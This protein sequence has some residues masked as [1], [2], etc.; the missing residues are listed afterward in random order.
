[1]NT[2][3]EV[4]AYDNQRIAQEWALPRELNTVRPPHQSNITAGLAKTS[5]P[6]ALP[7]GF[8]SPRTRLP[9]IPQNSSLP[10]QQLV[11][12]P[13]S[14]EMRPPA[15]PSPLPRDRDFS[16]RPS[17]GSHKRARGNSFDSNITSSTS[18]YIGRSSFTNLSGPQLQRL[19]MQLR[20]SGFFSSSSTSDTTSLLSRMSR[21]SIEVKPCIMAHTL[22][23]PHNPCPVCRY[24]EPQPKPR[25]YVAPEY[26]APQRAEVI[27]SDEMDNGILTGNA[28][29]RT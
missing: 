28:N 2:A 16:V 26:A 17:L 27:D 23:N 8:S 10:S 11:V 24:P 18:R 13:S 9:T 14:I 19:E 22:V 6:Q 5:V 25:V 3:T 1:V 12:E 29:V 20:D 15:I 7:L 21:L 4:E